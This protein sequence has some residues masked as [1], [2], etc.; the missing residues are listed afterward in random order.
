MAYEE[1]I[2]E[3]KERIATIMLNR[4]EKLNAYTRKMGKELLSALEAVI[5]NDEIN[6]L[7]I[8]GAGRALKADRVRP[9]RVLKTRRRQ[10]RKFRPRQANALPA[11]PHGK[12]LRS[13]AR[14]HGEHTRCPSIS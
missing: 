5:D 13:R 8:T 1:I 6:V 12:T 7:I 3:E 10:R 4:P 2:L 9:V 14:C 11:V